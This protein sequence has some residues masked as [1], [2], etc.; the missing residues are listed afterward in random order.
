MTHHPSGEVGEPTILLIW[1]LVVVVASGAVVAFNRRN[2][3]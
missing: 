3:R 1:W 2:Q